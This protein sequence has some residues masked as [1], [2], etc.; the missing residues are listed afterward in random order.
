MYGAVAV[1]TA[2]VAGR[3]KSSVTAESMDNR[4]TTLLVDRPMTAGLGRYLSLCVCY[5]PVVHGCRGDRWPVCVT[6][7]P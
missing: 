4:Q 3:K 2:A 5:H 6:I 7:P 1:V